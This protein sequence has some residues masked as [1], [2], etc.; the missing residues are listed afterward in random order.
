MVFGKKERR[1]Y[2]INRNYV[3]DYI[4]LDIKPGLQNLIGRREK[5]VFAEVVKK[6]DRRFKVIYYV[7]AFLV[8]FLMF[9]ILNE[10]S[11][12]IIAMRGI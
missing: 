5:V 12:Q 7:I 6:Y 9:I 8:F 2:S 10:I 11:L 1:K 4:G 3:G